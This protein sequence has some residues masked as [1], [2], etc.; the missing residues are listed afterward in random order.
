M[1]PFSHHEDVGEVSE[2]SGDLAPAVAVSTVHDTSK[3]RAGKQQLSRVV[4]ARVVFKAVPGMTEQWLQRVVEC[5]QARNAAIG[6]ETAASEMPHCPLA[7]PGVT[8]TVASTSNGFAIDVRSD[9]P[10]T[11]R[12]ILRRTQKH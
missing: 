12:E 11:A 4:G 8:A 1:S 7:L 3:T 10:E 9:N 2:V 6:F 5:H